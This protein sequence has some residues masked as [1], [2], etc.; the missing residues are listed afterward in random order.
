MS[1][2]F[3]EKA[4]DNVLGLDNT[5][6]MANLEETIN[7]NDPSKTLHEVAEQVRDRTQ[8]KFVPGVMERVRVDDQP[9]NFTKNVQN[10]GQQSE[11]WINSN[12]TLN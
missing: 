4:V 8:P 2:N 1:L 12:V 11:S 10:N 3:I 9:L 7:V 6:D 5:M